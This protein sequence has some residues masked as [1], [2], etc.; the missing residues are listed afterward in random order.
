MLS[1]ASALFKISPFPAPSDGS[2]LIRPTTFPSRSFRERNLILA[3]WGS[4]R[5]SQKCHRFMT[6][7]QQMTSKHGEIWY[8]RTGAMNLSGVQYSQTNHTHDYLSQTSS[9]SSGTKTL[10]WRIIAWL[11]NYMSICGQ[12]WTIRTHLKTGG[13]Y[14]SRDTKQP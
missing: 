5:R 9:C 3:P 8:T 10:D 11:E 4:T 12:L 14:V 7:E 1:A 2:S 13:R 6:L